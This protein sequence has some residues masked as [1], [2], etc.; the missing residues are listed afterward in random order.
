M[1]I[2]DYD[3]SI[4]HCPGKNNLIADTLS[5]LPDQEN[6]A[7]M[8]HNDG[9]IILYALAKRTSSKLRNQLQNFSREQKTDPVL[10]QQ[11]AG[12][13]EKKTTEYE[14]HDKI[15]YFL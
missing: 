2:Q 12:V 4:E 14:I 11:F 6:A 13:E 15:Y 10:Q 5:R 8:C 9:K 3:I 7:K 1:A